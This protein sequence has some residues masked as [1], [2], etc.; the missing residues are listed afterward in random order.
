MHMNDWEPDMIRYMSRHYSQYQLFLF[1]DRIQRMPYVNPAIVPV[2]AMCVMRSETPIIQEKIIQTSVRPLKI[3]SFL[4]LLEQ[5][6]AT[7]PESVEGVP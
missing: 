2:V 4:T 3:V 6:T 1:V 7:E 5:S